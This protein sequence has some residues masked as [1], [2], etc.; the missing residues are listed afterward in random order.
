MG[1]RVAQPQE[2]RV[3]TLA[4]FA[5]IAGISLV[6]LRRLIARGDV[7]SNRDSN[8]QG[9]WQGRQSPHDRA[10]EVRVKR[11]LTIN[12][13]EAARSTRATSPNM[14]IWPCRRLVNS[15][16]LVWC[17]RCRL[18]QNAVANASSAGALR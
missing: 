8:R 18:A 17:Y 2:D 6:T 14:E 13:I 3:L 11:P 1:N 16:R 5:S 9:D 7:S 4:E 12:H 10:L 15:I